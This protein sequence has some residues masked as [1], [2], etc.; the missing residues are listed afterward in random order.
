[1]AVSDYHSSVDLKAVAEGGV[2]NEDVMQQIWDISNIP[3]P[4]TDAIGSGTADNTYT[5]WVEDELAAPDITNSVAETAQPT[6]NN[7]KNGAR[8]GN[9]CQISIKQ[10]GV[11]HRAR[12]VDTI[13]YADELAY[14][15]ME[16]QKELRRDV[17]AIALTGQAGV[18]GATEDDPN[19]TAGLGAMITQGDV[20]SDALGGGFVGGAWAGRVPGT[21]RALT[22]TMVRDVAQ[23]VWEEGGNP[24]LLM[25][26]PSMIRGLSAYM[27]T[28]SARIATLTAETNQNGP[29]TGM[30]SVNVFLTDFGVELQ[31]I[32]NRLQQKYDSLDGGADSMDA[33]DAFILD[34]S[35]V[36]LAYLQGYQTDEQGKAGMTDVRLMSVDWCTKV[37]NRKAHGLIGDLDFTAAV[38]A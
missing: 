33:C 26:I 2:I 31:M 18:A 27:F 36:E 5:E 38:T 22:E 20:A 32:P 1:M 19:Y 9:H 11:T 29:A 12:N 28:D 25:S 37:L 23:M 10:V 24:S 6:Q 17:E 8:I 35:Y 16:R 4:L 34:P 13:G 7:A 14:Q 21:K 15:V 30:G 3:L